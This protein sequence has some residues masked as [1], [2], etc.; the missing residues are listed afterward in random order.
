M[1]VW[2]CLLFIRSG[3]NHLARHS[4][5]RKKKRQ[6]EKEMGRQHQGR[7]RPGIH[8]VPNGSEEQRKMEESGC[9]VICGAPMTVADKE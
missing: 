6:T 7:D 2:T 1:V 4:E 3:K 8:K 5:R 9:T